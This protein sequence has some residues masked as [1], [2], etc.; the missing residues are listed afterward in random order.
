MIFPFESLGS[1]DREVGLVVAVLIGFAFGFVL[2]RAGFG[3]ST[4]LAAQ[5]Y[6]NDMTVFKVMFGA[7]VT[8]MLGLVIADGLGLADFQ[9]IAESA[10]S[11]TYMWPMLI[12]GLLLGAGFIISGYCPGTSIVGAASGNLDA[13]FTIVG[14]GLGSLL[15]SEFFPL[16][17]GFYASG[18]QGQMFLYQLLD[19]PPALLAGGVAVMA[20]GCFVGAE[21]VEKIYTRKMSGAE[22]R[23]VPVAPRRLVFA[24]FGFAT[25]LGLAL[26]T[27][28]VGA[29]PQVETEMCA[30]CSMEKIDAEELA[31]RML[32]E[33][34]KLLILD[35]RER[36]AYEEKRIPGSEHRA[37]A[38]L[39]SYGLAY[40]PG[41]KD[42]VLVAADG[43]GY[44]PP[45]AMKYP[46]RVLMLEGGFAAWKKFALEE[47]P[48]L[49]GDASDEERKDFLF[50]TSVHQKMT[51]SKAA[52]PP[53]VKATNFKPPKKKRGGGCDG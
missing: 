18:D 10:A 35:T 28:P 16:I 26:L 19:I 48:A 13:L 37:L 2:E 21:V 17:Q 31:R 51:G 1:A 32:D 41:V 15:F 25:L 23:P 53:P 33:P 14:V 8:A 29:R 11:T 38:E 42:L 52:P 47:P 24:T 22:P 45:A 3:R 43:L 12:G 40:S 4:K 7:I 44:A 39:D 30:A 9:V 49:T 50:R 20:V 36:S 34:W 6:L 27:V 46:G 5:F